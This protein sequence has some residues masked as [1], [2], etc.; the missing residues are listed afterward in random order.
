[1]NQ[2][3][4][5]LEQADVFLARIDRFETL[6]GKKAEE[7]F[8][9]TKDL[10]VLTKAISLESEELRDVRES[11]RLV[12]IQAMKEESKASIPLIANQLT[13]IFSSKIK[14]F[15]DEQFGSVRKL[16][17]ELQ[18]HLAAF[19][20]LS[21]K[22]LGFYMLI[23]TL[24][25][26]ASCLACLYFIMS[27]QTNQALNQEQINLMFYGKVLMAKFNDLTSHDQKIIMDSVNSGR[28]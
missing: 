23:S 9:C 26:V 19:T 16:N 22:I 7:L 18:K 5:S 4:N 10:K 11:L 8:E 13:L 24:C 15:F 3:S 1:M 17:N 14:D 21:W 28:K 25:G 27:K 2:K 12:L 6:L 20:G